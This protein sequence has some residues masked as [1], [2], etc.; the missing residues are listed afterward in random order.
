MNERLDY[1]KIK[2][3]VCRK[4]TPNG[5]IS[6]ITLLRTKNGR[7]LS[8]NYG[9]KANR[10][11]NM[12]VWLLLGLLGW[13]L[14][15]G[16]VGTAGVKEKE[17]DAK[18]LM[19]QGYDCSAPEELEAV[20]AT[21]TKC[22]G[23]E[24]PVVQMNATYLVLQEAEY[25]RIPVRV[26]EVYRSKIAAYCGTYDHQTVVPRM[27]EVRK[28]FRLPY[29]ECRIAW[30]EGY[31]QDP[32]MRRHP[33]NPNATTHLNFEEVGDT[34]HTADHVDCEGG[35]VRFQ[36]GTTLSHMN[37]G[38]HLEFKMYVEEALVRKNRVI[39]HHSQ[40]QLSCKA[41]SERCWGRHATYVWD[42]PPE[43]ET[44]RLHQTRL[45]KGLQIQGEKG[46][47][48]F[49][50]NDGSMLRLIRGEQVERCGQAV[51]KTNYRAIFL[52]SD[53]TAPPVLDAATPSRTV[54]DL[55]RQSAR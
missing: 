41:N 25:V 45:V 8:R 22:E 1:L 23:Q 46:T 52:S 30:T 24:K 17:T 7:C 13:G 32:R 50:S 47:I 2:L 11:T 38:V 27:T 37:V 33:V 3:Q 4:W 12:K 42:M 26:C 54:S 39:L 36:D 49:L 16:V 55:V 21:P 19:F 14:G 6:L 15:P 31:Y 34:T 9:V 18:D 43:E 29:F 53:L 48:S 40:R 20:R 10:S 44:C 28:T 35:K 5:E 51:Y